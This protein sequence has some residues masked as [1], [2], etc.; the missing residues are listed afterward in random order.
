MADNVLCGGMCEKVQVLAVYDRCVRKA[1]S[2]CV[3]AIECCLNVSDFGRSSPKVLNVTRLMA[4]LNEPLALGLTWFH[5]Y[6][7]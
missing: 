6:L 5:Y 4:K 1:L 2:Q 3:L 7:Y